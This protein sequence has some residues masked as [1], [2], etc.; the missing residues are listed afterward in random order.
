MNGDIKYIM[1]II[2]KNFSFDATS[3]INK[4]LEIA[5]K[6]RDKELICERLS[7]IETLNNQIITG[8]LGFSERIMPS[9]I[10]LVQT[11]EAGYLRAGKMQKVFGSARWSTISTNAFDAAIF[12]TRQI[13]SLVNPFENPEVKQILSLRA[14]TQVILTSH[15][16]NMFAQE[17]IKKLDF[18]S[19][20]KL[21]GLEE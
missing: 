10:E 19:V 5:A 15:L 8:L 16:S 7:H 4:T 3:V 17:P 6:Q 9:V 14:N 1:E 13:L 12:D 2:Q 11:R 21:L 20:N 18:S